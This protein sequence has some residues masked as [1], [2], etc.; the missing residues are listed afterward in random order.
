MKQSTFGIFFYKHYFLNP[1]SDRLNPLLKNAENFWKIFF[2]NTTFKTKS[3]LELP[4]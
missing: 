3:I 1:L 4:F 2:T